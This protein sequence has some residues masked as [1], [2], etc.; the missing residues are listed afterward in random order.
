MSTKYPVHTGTAEIP[1]AARHIALTGHRPNRL[2]G[3]GIH[4][5]AYQHLQRDL[6]A[7]IEIELATH[8]TIVGH[9][10]MA[11]GADSVWAKALLAM[12]AKYP[13]RVYLHAQIPT[14]TQARRWRESDAV[15]FWHETINTADR[16]TVYGTLDAVESGGPQVNTIVSLMHMRN[17]GMVDCADLL[18]A[19]HDGGASGTGK[20]VDYA[21]KTDTEVR[22]VHPDTWFKK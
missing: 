9:S 22:V 2:G 12:R 13:G 7:F 21:R 5:P 17:R 20:T 3:W 10:G 4:T 16:V 15:T 8:D 11:L 19:I 6:E 1:P 14:R 18:L